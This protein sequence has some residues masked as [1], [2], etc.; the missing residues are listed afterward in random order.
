M[1]ANYT[2]AVRKGNTLGPLTLRFKA[3][4]DP[5]NLTGSTLVF[6]AKHATATIRKETGVDALFAISNAT[7]GE[8]TLELTPAETRTLPIGDLTRY[9]IEHR[10]SGR[11]YT[12]L[13]GKLLVSEWVN[14]D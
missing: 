12:L 11:Q 14:D 6:I 3:G 10:I 4:A 9:E 13:Q 5:V 8:A 1:P 2:I 7:A